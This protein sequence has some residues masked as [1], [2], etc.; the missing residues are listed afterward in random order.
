MS[1]LDVVIG[2]EEPR[3]WLA[4]G[5]CVS[6]ALVLIWGGA[7]EYSAER[8][9][10]EV[11]RLCDAG[12]ASLG[13]DLGLGESRSLILHSQVFATSFLWA[14]HNFARHLV[15][16]AVSR[17]LCFCWIHGDDRGIPFAHHTA[18]AIWRC[19]AFFLTVLHQT[20]GIGGGADHLSSVLW[21]SISAMGLAARIRACGV[22]FDGDDGGEWGAEYLVS[23]CPRIDRQL[24]VRLGS[25][26][27]RQS[28]DLGL[29]VALVFVAVA[30]GF[31]RSFDIDQCTVSQVPLAF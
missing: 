18:I 30:C 10:L 16:S 2:P 29:G 19:V 15:F 4:I 14:Q 17:G 3:F 21:L 22:G 1:E 12:D 23:T 28:V 20:R 8:A 7:Q 31:T 5:C 27:C 24:H 26:Y 13:F 9:T 25:P 11:H 6:I